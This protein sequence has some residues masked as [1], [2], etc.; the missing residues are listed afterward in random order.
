[1]A[2]KRS[3]AQALFGLGSLLF[4]YNNNEYVH[5]FWSLVPFFMLPNCIKFK[6]KQKK[7]QT[8]LQGYRKL[9]YFYREKCELLGGHALNRNAKVSVQTVDRLLQAIGALS[10]PDNRPL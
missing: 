1:M 9:Q 2:A 4:L 7:K 5:V 8:L 3:T 6:K 10:F